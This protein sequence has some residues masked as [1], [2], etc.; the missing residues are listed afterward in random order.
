[1]TPLEA[2]QLL[3]MLQAAWP[4]AKWETATVALYR[5]RLEALVFA[6]AQRIIDRL[7]ATSKWLP[8]V[9]EI[10][11]PCRSRRVETPRPPMVDRSEVEAH[12]ADWVLLA[13]EVLAGRR[14][15]PTAEQL[16]LF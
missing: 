4:Q 10:E 15:A 9:A 1:M 12:T 3:S 2:R 14:S 6:D 13:R 8:T 16:D 5:G 11:G 7:I